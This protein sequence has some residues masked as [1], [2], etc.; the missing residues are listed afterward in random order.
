MIEGAI[1]L[2]SADHLTLRELMWRFDGWHR[3]RWKH[4]S[5]ILWAIFQHQNPKKIPADRFSPYRRGSTKQGL[6]I[7]PQTIQ[8]LRCFVDA[9]GPET[10]VRVRLVRSGDTYKAQVLEDKPEATAG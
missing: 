7:T 10:A 6:A 4:T 1:G 8:A 3:E 9:G 2:E 5:A